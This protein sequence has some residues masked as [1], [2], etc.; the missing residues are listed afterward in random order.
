[1][2]MLR[3]LQP[4][5][6]KLQVSVENILGMK[7]PASVILVL[8]KPNINFAVGIFKFVQETFAPLLE[9]LRIEWHHYVTGYGKTDHFAH[10]MIFQ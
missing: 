8:C 10:N 9:H 1:M 3:H 2:C 7:N 4:Q 6:K 5:Q